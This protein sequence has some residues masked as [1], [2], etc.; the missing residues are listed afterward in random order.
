MLSCL[1]C[2]LV[3]LKLSPIFHYLSIET[4]IILIDIL[5]AITALW[6]CI[7]EFMVIPHYECLCVYANYIFC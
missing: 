6:S 7:I 1:E 2:S 3:N 4:Y 5:L